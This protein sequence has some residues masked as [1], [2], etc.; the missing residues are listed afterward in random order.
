MPATLFHH[1][2][3]PT[4]KAYVDLL[5]STAIKS[6]R[7]VEPAGQWVVTCRLSN[8]EINFVS[9][10][11]EKQRVCRMENCFEFY[12][13]ALISNNVLGA[14]RPRQRVQN[15]SETVNSRIVDV[16]VAERTKLLGSSEDA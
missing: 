2:S 1:V 8:R 16:P 11:A 15:G 5:L 4:A 9:V 14:P 3:G 12:C 7:I 13:S 6:A 10:Q